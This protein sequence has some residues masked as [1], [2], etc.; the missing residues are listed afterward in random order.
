MALY[1]EYRVG[2]GQPRQKMVRHFFPPL[3][4]SVL[5]LNADNNTAE[6]IMQQVTLSEG[7]DSDKFEGQAPEYSS[8]VPM[9]A[10]VISMAGCFRNKTQVT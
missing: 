6:D 10:T 1:P 5:S 4:S 7:V 8:R 2:G 9:G 3:K